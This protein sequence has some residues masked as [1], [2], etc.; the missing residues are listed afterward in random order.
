[1]RGQSQNPFLRSD[2]PSSYATLTGELTVTWHETATLTG[3]LTETWHETAT[4]TGELT[5]T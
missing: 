5:E 1:M 4:L 2:W 3:E